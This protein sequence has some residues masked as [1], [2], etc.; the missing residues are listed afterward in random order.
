SG[1]LITA[2]L[3]AELGREVLAIPGSIHAPQS[4]GC[5]ALIKQGARLVE[6][7]QDVLDE[8][9]LQR[10]VLQV[11]DL[12]PDESP[13]PSA[14]GHDEPTADPVLAAMGYDPVSQEALCA[15]T[16]LGPAALSARLFELELL[17]EVARLP[18]Q[19]FQRVGRA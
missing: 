9:H 2:R 7:A 12:L 16:G 13:P 3:A 17:G 18:G 15:R 5:H 14:A 4:R 11:G 8:L 6:T 1:S 10:P 19:L